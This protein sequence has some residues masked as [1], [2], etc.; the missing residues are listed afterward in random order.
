MKKF[1][2]STSDAIIILLTSVFVRLLLLPLASS[3]HLVGDEIYYWNMALAVSNGEIFTLSQQMHPPLWGYLLSISTFFSED[4]FGGRVFSV[5][6]NSLIP[7]FIFLLGRDVFDK[8]TGLVG[9]YLFA[10]FPEHLFFSHYL[11]AEPFFGLLLIIS[12]WLFF[13]FLTKPFRRI[14]FYLSFFIAGLALLTREFALF[15]FL[16]MI[17]VLCRNRL[18]QGKI[19]KVVIAVTLFSMP[20]IAYSLLSWAH[21]GHPVIL[22]HSAIS[23]SRK[24]LTSSTDFRETKETQDPDLKETIGLLLNR[25]IEDT[26]V[27]FRIQICKLWAPNSNPVIRLM[28]ISPEGHTDKWKYQ[29]KIGDEISFICGFTYVV[30]MILGIIG[31]SL[32]GGSDFK[33]FS[34]INITLLTVS[35]VIGFLVSRYRFPFFYLFGIY[36]AFSVIH[37]KEF[38]VNIHSYQRKIMLVS[39]LFLFFYIV[40]A[41]WNQFGIWG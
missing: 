29:T 6:L 25:N 14:N 33:L 41:T 31:I 18:I 30:V 11:W 19:H 13:R 40:C 21:T 9:G 22:A 32:S 26:L 5:F 17:V 28:G 15:H 34:L 38:L 27:N 3:L 37:R 23:S 7:V 10:L 8:K 4:P 39:A 16:G 20:A 24:A 35:G 36:A 1:I 2:L 12:S